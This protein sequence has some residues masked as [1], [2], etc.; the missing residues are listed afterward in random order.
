MR[1]LCDTGTPISL[2]TR[3]GG[4]SAAQEYTW[5]QWVREHTRVDRPL[6]ALVAAEAA[7]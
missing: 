3:L 6:A 2:L 1:L 5:A 7:L 4:G